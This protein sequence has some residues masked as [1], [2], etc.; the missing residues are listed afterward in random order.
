MRNQTLLV[1]AFKDL[2]EEEE[3]R[4][5]LDVNQ[6]QKK[7][8]A[9]LLLEVQLIFGEASTGDEQITNL[10]T[11]ILLNLERILILLLLKE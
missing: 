2:S 8:D 6:K 1:T 11:S 7:V 3:A 5:F 4:I 10:A 9:G